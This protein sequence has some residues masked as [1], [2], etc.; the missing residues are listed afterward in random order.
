MFVTTTCIFIPNFTQN[1][2]IMQKLWA[3]NHPSK[4]KELRNR[5]SVSCNHFDIDKF[6]ARLVAK[7]F[8]QKQGLDF[9]ETYSLVIH[10]D[11]IRPIFATA[12]A[13]RMHLQQFDIG[14][15]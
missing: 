9:T 2:Q 5:T 3:K 13:R 14:I 4:G 8:T 11:S 15:A 7:R 1:E 10:Y 12:T 6:K